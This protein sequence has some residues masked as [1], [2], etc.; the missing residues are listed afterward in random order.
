[1]RPARAL[2][3]MGILSAAQCSPRPPD[4]YN[5]GD[6]GAYDSGTVTCTPG[7]VLCN[8]NERYECESDGTVINRQACGGTT[9]LCF[10]GVGCRTCRPGSSRCN[11]SMPQQ[12]QTCRSDGMG[13]DDG[14]TCSADN[15][16]TCSGGACTDRCSDSA[17]GRSYLGCDYWPTVTA[18]S[19]LDPLFEFAVVLSNPQTYAVRATISGGALPSPRTLML[20]PNA[21]QT[22]TLPWVP[23]LIQF[24]PTNRG[25]RGTEIGGCPGANPARSALRT[26]G[27]YHVHSNGPIAA[28]QFNPLNFE[29]TGGYHSFTNDASLLLPQGVLTQRYVVSTASNWR[30]SSGVTLG[31]FVS[32]VGV[33][34]ESTTVTVRLTATIS[35]GTGVAAAPA[36]STQTYRLQPG[37]VVQ[38]VGTGDG[39]LTGTVIDSTLPVAVFVG[40]DC[41]NV[42]QSRP[43]CDHV[44]EQLLPNETWGREYVVTAL[45][46]R[47]TSTPSLLR[48]VSQSDNNQLTFLPAVRPPATLR[49]GQLLEFAATDSFRVTGTGAFLVSQFMIGQ[50]EASAGPGAGDPAM[51]FEVP[52]Q[53]FRT[54]YDFF[55][56][57]T[58]T[59][60]FINIVGPAGVSLTMDGQPLRGSMQSV[61]AY[62]VFYLP[63]QSGPHHLQSAG[64]QP[65]GIKV[66]GIAQYTSYMYPGGLDLR[67][68]TP[69]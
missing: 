3:L 19:Q 69:G 50:G 7:M 43:A 22:V 29:R 61:G 15:G 6:G 20:A 41:T 68:I 55:V 64:D 57:S 18:N 62:T 4:T 48:I 30:T 63:I 59:S 51:V 14:P 21:V 40:H 27:A 67:V 16:Q 5:A 45:R 35:G 1:M 60:N 31:G 26:G 17:L 46:D 42:P 32:I 38:L 25:C 56:P 36:G 12:I 34:G 11:P 52:V 49:A 47:G 24:N 9:P 23:E 39:D 53:Q 66:Y 8:G 28:Y 33:S 2:F 37:D 58:Y 65:F 10:P 13:Y 54:S 44:E